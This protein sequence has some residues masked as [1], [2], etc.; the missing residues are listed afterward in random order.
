MKR[1]FL[2]IIWHSG[3]QLKNVELSG[4]W[5]RSFGIPVRRSPCWAQGLGASIYPTQMREIFSRQL[6]VY[7]WEDVQCFNCISE[8]S[9]Q[10]HEQKICQSF[11]DYYD[12]FSFQSQ[13]K[14][15]FLLFLVN[16]YIIVGTLKKAG[17]LMNF[18]YMLLAT[19]SVAQLAE[20]RTRFAG[21]RVRFPAGRPK[22]ALTQQVP[23]GS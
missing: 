7:P 3:S 12:K 23:V 6:N 19:A 8:S 13:I 21:S 2:R 18:I 5:T 10:I 15:G 16:L 14:R 17:S 11:W 9:S 22:V 4:I 1:K 20:H